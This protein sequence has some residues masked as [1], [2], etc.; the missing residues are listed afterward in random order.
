MIESRLA[1]R[2][3]NGGAGRSHARHGRDVD[4]RPVRLAERRHGR[5]RHGPGPEDV[6]LENAA[7]DVDRCRRQVMVRNHCGRAGIVDQ[8]VEPA[9]ALQRGGHHALGNVRLRDVALDVKGV[10][11]RSGDRLA[12]LDRAGRIDQ[13]GGTLGGERPRR[14]GADTTGGARDGDDLPLQ[15]RAALRSLRLDAPAGRPLHA[16][17]PAQSRRRRYAAHWAG[18]SSAQWRPHAGVAGPRRACRPCTPSGTGSRR[19]TQSAA[20]PTPPGASSVA[21]ARPSASRSRVV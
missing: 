11:Q 3:R 7:P 21:R 20:P 5:H 17:A 18:R 1:G 10:G 14:R 8:R 9:P 16:P 12:F 13:D 15:G 2:V 19:S 6:D 4:H